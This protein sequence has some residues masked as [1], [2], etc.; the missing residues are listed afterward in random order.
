MFVSVHGD[1]K[2]A[3]ALSKCSLVVGIGP[4]LRPTSLHDAEE[5]PVVHHALFRSSR[6]RL[7]LLRFRH[8]GRLVLHLTGTCQTAVDLSHCIG[9]ARVSAATCFPLG[10][11]TTT[12]S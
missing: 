4:A 12:L 10:P 7:L 3:I 11:M 2:Q 1:Y 9:L 6:Q 8:L 5:T